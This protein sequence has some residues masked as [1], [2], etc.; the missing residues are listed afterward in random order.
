MA[1][2]TTKD[3]LQAVADDIAA[4]C[5][6]VS[7]REDE[8][9]PLVLAFGLNDTHSLEL[10]KV[11]DNYFLELWHGKTAE[12]EIVVEELTFSSIE[13]ARRKAEEWLLKDAV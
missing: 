11:G 2:P 4:I 3:Q 13:E 12:V 5:C 6:D 9:G 7:L 10:R 8:N 1:M